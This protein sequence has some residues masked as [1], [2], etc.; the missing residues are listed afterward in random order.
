ML[1]K[2]ILGAAASMSLLAASL[3][4]GVIA[5]LAG[6]LAYAAGGEGVGVLAALVALGLSFGALAGALWH[7]G[8]RI[9]RACS[10]WLAA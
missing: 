10:R 3:I 8:P 6:D 4:V 2:I 7:G 1:R 9:E 5:S